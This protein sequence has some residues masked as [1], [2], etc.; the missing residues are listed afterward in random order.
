MSR[1]CDDWDDSGE[2][3]PWQFWEH[4]LS[5]AL[6]GKR[7]QQA[8]RDLREALMA[9]PEHKLIGGAMCTV[10]AAD[11]RPE[12]QRHCG[13]DFDALVESN[14]EGVCAIGAFIW[15]KHVKA[16]MGPQEAFAKLPTLLG[17][18]GDEG[19]R[20]SNL[21]QTAGLTMT[22]AWHLAQKNDDSFEAL[23]PED[24]FNAFIEWIDKQIAEST[25]LEQPSAKSSGREESRRSPGP[26]SKGLV[27]EGPIDADAPHGPA[28]VL[29]PSIFSGSSSSETRSTNQDAASATMAP[30]PT[31]GTA[32]LAMTSQSQPDKSY[33]AILDTLPTPKSLPSEEQVD[34]ARACIAGFVIAREQIG[35]NCDLLRRALDHL[36][37]SEID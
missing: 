19:W 21:G 9:L 16:G 30:G 22:L 20:T 12:Y 13:G 11:R 35:E 23:A 32:E 36:A 8:L 25:V 34:E 4:N 1:F 29:E 17:V 14:G 7:G 15:H 18:D 24:R 37:G 27:G 33:S 28:T 2:G 31:A 6:G 5:M 10:G 26:V 3:M